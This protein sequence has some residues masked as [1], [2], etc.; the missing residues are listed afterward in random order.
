MVGHKVRCQCGFVF[1]IGSKADKQ[2]GVSEKLNRKKAAKPQSPVATRANQHQP[3]VAS[4][5]LFD[6]NGPLNPIEPDQSGLLQNVPTPPRSKPLENPTANS[7]TVNQ[8]EVDQRPE[9]D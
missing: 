1:R 2:P 5:G 7:K 6:L 9:V 3:D 4:G 8:P